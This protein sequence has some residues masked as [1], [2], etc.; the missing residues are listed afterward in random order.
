M[1]LYM[2]IVLYA[3]A[4]ALSAVTG[5]SKWTSI[6][7]LGLVCSFYSTIGGMKAVLWTDV[8]QSVLIFFAILIVLLKGF[9][10]AG[11]LKHV[12]QSV[13][14]RLE[15]F[16]LDL[17]PT[18]RHTFWTQV[19]GGVFTF[20]AIYGVNQAQVQR[21]LT[22]RDLR[23]SQMSLFLCWPIL[24][25]LN[26]MTSA[27]GIIIYYYYRNC[28]PLTVGRISSSDQ[29][30]PLFVMDTLSKYPGILGLFVSGVFSA[31]LSTVSSA[32]N[33]LAAVTLEDYLKPCLNTQWSDAK[34]A[35][36]SQI[37]VLLYGAVCLTVTYVAEQLGDVLQASL[38]VFGVVGGPI[39]GLFSLGMFTVRANQKG[40]IF[41]FVCSLLFVCWIGFGASFSGYRVSK[42]PV[43]VS[44]CSNATFTRN[45]IE[46]L[47][48][49]FD[50]VELH[51]KN[52]PPMHIQISSNSD[53]IWYWY[54]L[55]YMWLAP[56]GFIIA[57]LFGYLASCTT[58]TRDS[59]FILDPM[60]ISP[61]FLRLYGMQRTGE[62]I[63]LKVTNDY[64]KQGDHSNQQTLMNHPVECVTRF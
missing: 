12:L 41:G 58:V 51:E 30:M 19:I 25:V 49:T 15:F 18:V 47:N 2:G 35:F 5:L 48:V 42:L 6:L 53:Q 40:A 14:S 55:S 57:F 62:R 64:C 52:E 1:V 43:S 20:T 3:P 37:L 39:L 16:R 63:S 34:Q 24:T 32:V 7:S 22:I 56:L 46:P 13:S 8:F 45:R 27:C 10:D 50:Y 9:L 11:D 33:S 4:L 54:R 21:L 61:P 36:I 38:T 60:L 59:S 29:L 23:N 31:T 28:D 44:G 26:I 17:D